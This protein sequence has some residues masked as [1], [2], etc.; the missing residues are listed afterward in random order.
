MEM[1]VNIENVMI[2]FC[3]VYVLFLVLVEDSMLGLIWS[4]DMFIIDM[5]IEGSD[6]VGGSVWYGSVVSRRF[7]FSFYGCKFM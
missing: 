6:F 5:M 2:Y 4:F 1:Y 3:V 7:W